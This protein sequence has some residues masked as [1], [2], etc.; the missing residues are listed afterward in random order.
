MVS[1]LEIEAHHIKKPPVK[2][3]VHT[4][5]QTNLTKNN[6]K[7]KSKWFVLQRSC[8]RIWLVATSSTSTVCTLLFHKS[9]WDV[10]RL[11]QTATAQPF[12][13]FINHP[14]NSEWQDNIVSAVWWGSSPTHP[15]THCMS[16]WAFETACVLSMFI[17][18]YDWTDGFFFFSVPMPDISPSTPPICRTRHSHPAEHSR[19]FFNSLAPGSSCSAGQ[20][21]PVKGLVVM[22]GPCAHSPLFVFY[23]II[24]PAHLPR[25]AP[26]K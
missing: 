24:S 10:D 23:V 6:D 8:L 20:A 25:P 22:G 14:S 18:T 17:S 26:S 5:T 19:C 11:V 9:C 21:L 4:Y 13:I 2:I 1:G 16:E 7:L 3:Y 12:F 15:S